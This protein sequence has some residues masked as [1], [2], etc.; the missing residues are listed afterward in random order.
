MTFKT[1]FLYVQSMGEQG[2][3][4]S[5]RDFLRSV[6]LR[7]STTESTTAETPPEIDPVKQASEPAT[8]PTSNIT[9]DGTLKTQTFNTRQARTKEVPEAV[10]PEQSAAFKAGKK[11][12]ERIITELAISTDDSGK[13]FKGVVKQRKDNRERE[14]KANMEKYGSRQPDRLQKKLEKIEAAANALPS[15]RRPFLKTIFKIIL[16]LKF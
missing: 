4:V 2:N 11:T 15:E 7:G 3:N 10:N 13:V 5:R 16:G 8:Q 9:A 12:G 1:D 14:E 6:G